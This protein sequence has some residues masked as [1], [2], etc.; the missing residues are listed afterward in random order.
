MKERRAI[1]KLESGL[2]L[3]VI[4]FAGVAA[5]GF[6]G[7]AP[8]TTTTVTATGGTASPLSK[9]KVA[10]ILPINPTDNSWNYQADSA[11]KGLQQAYGFTLNETTDKA[12]GTD[13]QP[14]AVNYAQKGFN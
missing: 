5:Y 4:I 3:L 11:V 8:G 10:L 13:A 2:V 7:G 6:L 12:T 1:T 14:V 9:L